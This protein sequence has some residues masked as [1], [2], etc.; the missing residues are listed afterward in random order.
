MNTFQKIGLGVVGA[1]LLV[2][3]VGMILEIPF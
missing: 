1:I 3:L 2:V